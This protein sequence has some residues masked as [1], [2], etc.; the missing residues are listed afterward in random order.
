MIYGRVGASIYH[1]QTRSLLRIAG[2]RDAPI[3]GKALLYKNT[4][5]VLDGLTL[6]PWLKIDLEN[7]FAYNVQNTK[8]RDRQY[9]H[10]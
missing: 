3:K 4:K 8:R 2:S 6:T 7:F 1:L 5:D 9:I 10:I